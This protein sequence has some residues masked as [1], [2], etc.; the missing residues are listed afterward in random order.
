MVWLLRRVRSGR[1]SRAATPLRLYSAPTAPQSSGRQPSSRNT[2]E[3]RQLG[4]RRK[5]GP[6]FVCGGSR[7]H[8]GPRNHLQ[9]F[10]R[11]HCSPTPGGR[12]GR[13]D[14][15]ARKGRSPAAP[16]RF[17]TGLAILGFNV[18][19]LFCLTLIVA[20]PVFF[21]YPLAS[22]ADKSSPGMGRSDG[23]RCA[24]RVRYCLRG[25]T[26]FSPG[27]LIH[28]LGWGGRAFGKLAH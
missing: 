7:L 9:G 21:S 1:N 24:C 22:C 2:R 5:R 15:L 8:D 25:R 13:P 26:C 27:I 12:T 28:L 3:P 16:V 10:L 19:A 14:T 4:P 23:I 6:F 20:S 17:L 11:S 18:S